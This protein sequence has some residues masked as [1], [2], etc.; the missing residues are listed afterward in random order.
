MPTLSGSTA[1]LLQQQGQLSSGTDTLPEFNGDD[2]ARAPR[3]I[4]VDAG[5]FAATNHL[6]IQTELTGAAAAACRS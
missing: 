2:F 6:R 1:P 5:H 3:Y 4:T